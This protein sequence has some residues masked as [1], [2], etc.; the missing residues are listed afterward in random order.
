MGWIDNYYICEPSKNH[1]CKMTECYIN[2]G[3][4]FLT[5]DKD[6]VSPY[7]TKKLVEKVSPTLS[8]DLLPRTLRQIR[9]QKI[10]S[11]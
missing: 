7:I 8:S 3:M 6:A 9:S 5:S 4:C 11:L 1:N 2:G 10:Q